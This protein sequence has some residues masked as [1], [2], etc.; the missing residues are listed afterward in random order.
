MNLQPGY[1]HSTYQWQNEW[2]T[3]IERLSFIR[4]LV[5]SFVVIIEELEL[6]ATT[7][8]TPKLV[9]SK[10]Q[11]A[12]LLAPKPSESELHAASILTSKLAES[13]LHTES[14][15]YL[16]L[17]ESVLHAS[18]FKAPEPSESDLHA[19]T[20][21][22]PKPSESDLHAAT[23]L[24]PKPAESDLHASSFKALK[25]AESKLHTATLL[26]PSPA[27]SKLHA[28]TLLAPKPV[29]SKLQNQSYKRKPPPASQL[30]VTCGKACQELDL[31]RLRISFNSSDMV[32]STM[33]E[34]P[35]IKALD[36]VDTGQDSLDI[37][38]G[39]CRLPGSSG[40]K[41]TET[42][43]GRTY[44]DRM[45]EKWSRHVVQLVL[46]NSRR[47]YNRPALKST[48]EKPPPV[49]PTEIRASISPSS[50]VELNTTSALANYATEADKAEYIAAILNT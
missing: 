5:L 41:E 24:A 13:K 19:A 22:A 18:S 45:F 30:E 32:K 36:T 8:I 27:E 3:D 29:E 31:S 50:A 28:A 48:L 1:K 46:A 17:A 47:T 7:L 39:Q 4:T 15:L 43:V 16:K 42:R 23:L 9:E 2:L 26:A 38:V 34:G 21:L 35:E 20:L 14:L 25:P 33:D 44:G 49:H 6:H 12:T 10:L 37:G 11:V 40:K